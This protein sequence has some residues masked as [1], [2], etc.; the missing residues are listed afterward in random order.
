M[1]RAK[2]W[3]KR[4]RD[5]TQQGW[6]LNIVTGPDPGGPTVHPAWPPEL[7]NLIEVGRCLNGERDSVELQVE[8]HARL[9]SQAGPIP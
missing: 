3:D 8:E 1:G 4:R 6:S 2:W 5:D 9:A 7:W